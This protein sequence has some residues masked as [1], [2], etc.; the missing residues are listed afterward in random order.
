MSA[1]I[2]ELDI[3]KVRL[4]GGTQTRASINNDVVADYLE[5]IGTLPPVI[6]YFDG[7]DYW[8]AD[9]FHRYH[10]HL[11]DG[12]KKIKAVVRNG[13]V[14]E[15]I[16]CAVGANA[17]HGLHRTPA[18]KKKSVETLLNDPEWA[19]WSTK[20]IAEKCRVGWHFV[21][22]LKTLFTSRARSDES[23]SQVTYKNKHGQT[24]TMNTANIGKAKPA[25]ESPPAEPQTPQKQEEPIDRINADIA[26]RSKRAAKAT[27]KKPTDAVGVDLPKPLLPAFER[28]PEFRSF[29]K[30]VSDLKGE[31]KQLCDGKGG[32][33][34]GRRRQQI[35]AIISNLHAELRFAM[36]H[37]V[38]P[39]CGGEKCSQ[40]KQTGY[41]PEEIY[42]ATPDALKKRKK[43][44]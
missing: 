40:C 21:D 35:E 6:V 41:L 32:E 34:A 22:D 1:K 38:C 20:Q 24:A 9:G 43:A 25:E 13:N 10:A 18:D 31:Y 11:N 2:Q 4:D 23:D 39:S 14:R 29:M 44:A 27:E 3:K 8:L 17:D 37:A 15:A 28:I 33:W 16:L 42:K 30:R 7:V 19:K 36:P 5:K 26:A 12:R